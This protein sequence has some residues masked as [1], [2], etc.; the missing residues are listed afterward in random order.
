MS[1]T[2]DQR[3]RAAQIW[4]L[5]LI[6]EL[7]IAAPLA[8]ASPA[9]AQVTTQTGQQQSSGQNG[10]LA[11]P[12]QA[13]ATGVFCIEEMTATFCNVTARPNAGG[14]G[15]GGGSGSGS[16]AGGTTP[17]IPPCPSEPPFNELCN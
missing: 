4:K 7:L 5:A 12:A 10:Q 15:S 8:V 6:A 1:V 16:S 3:K 11:A 14:Y 13:P 9:A 2:S 17:S